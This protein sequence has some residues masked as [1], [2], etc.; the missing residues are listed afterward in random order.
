MRFSTTLTVLVV[1]ATLLSPSKTRSGLLYTPSTM[2]LE[3]DLN[4]PNATSEPGSDTSPAA[5]TVTM[6]EPSER[7][8]SNLPLNTNH[9]R[10]HGAGSS[11]SEPATSVM[12]NQLGNSNANSMLLPSYLHQRCGKNICLVIFNF[13]IHGSSGT[14]LLMSW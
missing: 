3:P 12:T 8:S 9:H 4:R 2:S 11:T 10:N 13:W 1:I 5:P 6:T 14:K 7:L